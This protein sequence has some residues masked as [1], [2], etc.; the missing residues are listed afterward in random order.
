MK[1][2]FITFLRLPGL[3][4]SISFSAPVWLSGGDSWCVHVSGIHGH[5]PD[6][7]ELDSSDHQVH[8]CSSQRKCCLLSGFYT[9]H[10]LLRLRALSFECVF[11]STENNL[12]N[13]AQILLACIRLGEHRF[14]IWSPLN[15]LLPHLK[16]IPA[17]IF[18]FSHL[19]KRSIGAKVLEAKLTDGCV[20]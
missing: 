18:S 11:K 10:Y 13:I 1:R 14:V 4:R 17:L 7:V 2:H 12:R 20:S 9:C 8:R 15:L 6:T 3:L 19:S 5:S 16:I